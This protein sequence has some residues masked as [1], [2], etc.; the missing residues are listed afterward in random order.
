[1]MVRRLV[2]GHRAGKAIVIT[3]GRVPRS[4]DFEHIPGMATALVW[5]TPPLPTVPH[6]G[7]DP[8]SP[9]STFVPPRG[10]TRLMVM[11]L[12]PLSVAASAFDAPEAVQESL[13]HMTDL[14]AKMESEN[15]GMHVTDTV[16]YAI[17]L[18]G[19][20][21]LELDDGEQVHLK[22]QDIVIQNGT[23]HGWRNK[24]DKPV[25]IAFVLIGADRKA[26]TQ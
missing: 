17:V 8:I 4:H 5:S 26:A 13:Q 16:D 9:Q 18:E 3:D 25:K 24:T 14:G 23:R 6:N 21:W 19:E 15:P 11:S 22:P 7:P 2:T 1:M 20:V 10:E 12:P